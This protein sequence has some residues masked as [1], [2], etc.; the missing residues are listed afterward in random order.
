MDIHHIP[1]KK[2][3]A[4]ALNRQLVPDASIRKD[5]VKDAN[6]EYVMRLRVASNATDEGIQNA[7]YKL[8]NLSPQGEFSSTNDQEQPSIMGATAVSKIQLGNA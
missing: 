6:A 2:D 1:G 4:D 3:P 7:L 5:S 8:F